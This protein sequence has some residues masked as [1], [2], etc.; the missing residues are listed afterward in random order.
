M[1]DTTV[2]RCCSQNVCR[3]KLNLRIIFLCEFAAMDSN[4]SESIEDPQ[5][6]VDSGKM[7]K[8][9]FSVEAPGIVENVDNFIKCC[10]GLK[11][12]ESTF[13]NSKQRLK[14]KFR[15][16]DSNSIPLFSERKPTTDLAVKVRRKKKPDGSYDYKFET[17]GLI[18]TV[19]HFDDTLCDMQLLPTSK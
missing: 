12:I 13:K 11:N 2:N 19:F 17:Y 4:M 3:S 9:M 6:T 18:E 14:F 16:E 8:K 15:P 7:L 10:G 1:R 5:S